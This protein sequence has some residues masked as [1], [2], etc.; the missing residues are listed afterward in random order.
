[1]TGFVCRL[2]GSRCRPAPVATIRGRSRALPGGRRSQRELTSKTSLSDIQLKVTRVD[3]NTAE[4]STTL[5]DIN[6]TIVTIQGDIAT[7]KTDI[8]SIKVQLALAQ[9][10]RARRQQRNSALV[11]PR[12]CSR[13]GFHV[14]DGFL[15]AKAQKETGLSSKLQIK[16]RAL[17]RKNRKAPIEASCSFSR[18]LL[19][20]EKT[21]RTYLE[22]N[23]NTMQ[24]PIGS[25]D[26][27]F[28]QP[29]AC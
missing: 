22:P 16:E 3:G 7:I 8:G 9:N 17:N 29:K 13:V 18:K 21:H 2:H 12:Q 19:T 4:I 5:G 6:G 26:W 25:T 23:R 15:V 20:E 11:G 28:P 1:M 27:L 24:K 14:A 10:Q